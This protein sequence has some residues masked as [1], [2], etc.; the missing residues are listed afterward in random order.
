MRTRLLWTLVALS[1]DKKTRWS[2]TRVLYLTFTM[3][4]TALWIHPPICKAIPARLSNENQCQ[5]ILCPY[6]QHLLITQILLFKGI[7]W[8]PGSW[9]RQRHPWTV[10]DLY[11]KGAEKEITIAHFSKLTVLRKRSNER[12]SVRNLSKILPNW[13]QH[14]GRPLELVKIRPFWSSYTYTSYTYT[15]IYYLKINKW[16]SCKQCYLKDTWWAPRLLKNVRR[17]AANWGHGTNMI[18]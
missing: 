18:Q 2:A 9:Q 15:Y 12:N 11:L 10:E 1:Q 7:C 16:N 6:V 8:L 17:G 4:S 13:G 3:H 14:G 5:L